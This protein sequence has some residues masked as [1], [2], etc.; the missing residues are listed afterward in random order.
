MHP[1]A[2]MQPLVTARIG[3]SD[4]LAVAAVATGSTRPKAVSDPMKLVANY[5]TLAGRGNIGL[6][7]DRQ[8]VG[9]SF[10]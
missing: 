9:H 8:L 6:G 3:S 7:C 10:S 4:L 1:S 2:V 5:R